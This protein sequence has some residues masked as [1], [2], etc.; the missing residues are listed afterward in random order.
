MVPAM[1]PDK[2]RFDV[3]RSGEV[4]LPVNEHLG[5]TVEPTDD[6]GQSVSYSW[7]VPPEYCNTAGN[8][9]GGILASFADSLLGAAAGAHIPADHYPALVEMKI[10]FLRPAPAGTRLYG[11]GHVVKKGK[12]IMFVEAEV[13][14]SEGR[15]LAKVS[16][17]EIPTPAP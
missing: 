4:R 13:S 5:F 15:L 2:T 6:P 3:V 10:S 16:G 1:A 14:D 8:L 17:T 7:T 9:Q 12:R 11:K